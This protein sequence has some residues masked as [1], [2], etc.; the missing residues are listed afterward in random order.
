[1]ENVLVQAA[2]YLGTTVLAVPL[3]ARLGLGSVLGFLA[4]GLLIGPVLGLVGRESEE[5]LH[6]GEYGIAVMLF[7]VG[8]EVSPRVLWGLRQI[9]FFF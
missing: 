5:L 4:G 9:F 8:L 3:A 1:M 7:L 2:I 6:F